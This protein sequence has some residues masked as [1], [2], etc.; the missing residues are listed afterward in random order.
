LERISPG[1]TRS[2]AASSSQRM[3]LRTARSLRHV[4]SAIVSTLGQQKP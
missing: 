2:K 1:L 4:R 3:A